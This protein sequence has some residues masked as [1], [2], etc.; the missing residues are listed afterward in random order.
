MKKIWLVRLKLTAENEK[1][2]VEREKE[3]N[4]RSEEALKN[5]VESRKR[6]R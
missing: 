4:A 6:R 2:R 1:A 5:L 3:K